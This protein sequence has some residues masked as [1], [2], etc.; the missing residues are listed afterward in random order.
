MGAQNRSAIRA[1]A[2]A[3]LLVLSAGGVSLS[4]GVAWAQSA[5]TSDD[6]RYA[7]ETVAEGLDHPWGLVFLPE[8]AMLVTERPGRLRIIRDGVLD[9]TPIAG[10]PEVLAESQGGLLDIALHPDYAEN[11]LVY[12]TY[13]HG[14]FAAN[15]TRLA[16]ARFSGTALE[17]LE[18][19]Y[20]ANPLKRGAAHFGGRLAF[21]SASTLFMTLGD[22]FDFREDAQRLSTDLGSILRLNDDGSVPVDNPFVGREDAHG[23]IWSF[24]HRNV[25]GIAVDSRSGRVY[26]HE[27]GPRGGDELNLIRRGLNYG[28]PVITYGVD[29]SG[30]LISPFTDRPG[31]EQPLKYWTPSI[32]PSGLAL[33]EGEAFADWNGDLLVAALVPGDVRRIDLDAGRILGEE[34]LFDELGERIRDVRV[35]PDGAIYLLTDNTEGRILRVVPR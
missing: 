19:L 32:A 35:G 5:P 18:V 33:Y 8:G 30:A 24:G 26:A 15:G 6:P 14:T 17:N 4:A 21:G 28:W 11:R 22:G 27:H 29:Y 7:Y 20:T 2:V 31:M 1:I 23:A 34:I 16:R 12:L 13:S 9:A 25:Q 3:V 10:V